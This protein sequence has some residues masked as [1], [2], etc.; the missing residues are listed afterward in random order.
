[1]TGRKGRSGAP[2]FKSEAVRKHILQA[3]RSG[4]FRGEA[5]RLA[6]VAPD[7]LSRWLSRPEPIFVD[8]RR[9]VAHA[10]A[11]AEMAALAQIQQAAW[12]DHRAAEWILERRFPIRWGRRKTIKLADLS[13]D[14]LLWILMEACGGSELG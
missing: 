11:E 14:D 13:D 5:A 2:K 3:L 1:M 9:E 12:Q 8:F 10:E 7:T 6:G 4:A